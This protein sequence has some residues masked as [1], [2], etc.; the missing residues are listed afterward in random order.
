MKKTLFL[1]ISDLKQYDQIMDVT[2]D[3]KKLGIPYDFAVKGTTQRKETSFDQRIIVDFNR[4]ATKYQYDVYI[5]P[6]KAGISLSTPRR[7]VSLETNVQVPKDIK[8]GGKFSGDVSF[9]LD[10]KNAPN[11]KS[12]IEGW[13]N[14]DVNKGYTVNGELKLNH[15]GLPRVRMRSIFFYYSLDSQTER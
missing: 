2:V 15:P 3:L 8:E 13:L 4:G 11:K 9:Y 7:L 1:M 6:S 12:S 5:H 14:V 10:K